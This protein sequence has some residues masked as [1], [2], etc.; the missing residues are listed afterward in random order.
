MSPVKDTSWYISYVIGLRLTTQ[1]NS[2]LDLQVIQITYSFMIVEWFQL[3]RGGYAPMIGVSELLGHVHSGEGL[4]G[5]CSLLSLSGLC[6][7][8]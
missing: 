3:Y 5:F 1:C 8:L 4:A 6:D 2:L 7:P